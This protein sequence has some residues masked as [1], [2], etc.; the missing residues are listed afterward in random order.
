MTDSGGGTGDDHGDAFASATSVAVPSTTDGEL[1]MGGDKDYFRF[2]VA[3]AATLTVE[4]GGS[5]DTYGTLFDSD[6]RSLETDDDNGR[7][8]NFKIGR[9]VQAG[10]YYVE[11]RGYS[12]STTGA[13]Q[14]HVSTPGGDDDTDLV[15]EPAAVDDNMPDP[16]GSF[17][18]SATIRNQGGTGVS[19]ATTLRYY[20]SDDAAIGRGD[21]EVGTD[22]VPA[23]AAGE[24]TDASIALT[25]PSEAGTYYYGACV[26]A[27]SGE[28]DTGNNCSKGVAVTVS[29]TPVATCEVELERSTAAGGQDTVTFSPTDA[30]SAEVGTSNVAARVDAEIEDATDFDV[31]KITLNAD[32]RAPPRGGVPRR[33]GSSPGAGRR[34]RAETFCRGVRW[35]RPSATRWNARPGCR[36]TCPTPTWRS[37]RTTW[38]GR[39]GRSRP[40][41]ATGCSPGRRSAP[42]ASA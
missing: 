25:A 42:S 9:D 12:S 28:S 32:A 36:C 24:D 15:V 5:T 1:E 10:T 40:E 39:C 19:A 3:A 4:T 23:L 31:Y 22:A 26:D 34:V 17:T 6:E 8:Y 29:A 7:V 13:Y 27:V 16:G 35:R 33:R 18:L 14:L 30:Q 21:T 20:R 41:G 11:V 38:K 37:T 2:E